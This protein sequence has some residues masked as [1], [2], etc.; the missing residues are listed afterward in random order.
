MKKILLP[1]TGAIFC[2]ATFQGVD[3]AVS[4][5]IR[6]GEEWHAAVTDMPTIIDMSY[7]DPRTWHRLPSAQTNKSDGEELDQPIGFGFETAMVSSNLNWIS[8]KKAH[9]R[10]LKSY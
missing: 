2:V 1:L 8:L 6:P 5:K 9:Q 7:A 4:D 10:S 3:P